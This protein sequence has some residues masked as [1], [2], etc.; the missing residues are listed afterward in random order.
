[1]SGHIG[2]EPEHER[3]LDGL[4]RLELLFLKAEALDLLEVLSGLGGHDVTI[5]AGV[6]ARVAGLLADWATVTLDGSLAV[7]TFFSSSGAIDGAGRFETGSTVRWELSGEVS[8]DIVNRG[9]LTL[10]SYTTLREAVLINHGVITLETSSWQDVLRGE[11]VDDHISRIENGPGGTITTAAGDDGER[12]EVHVPVV[13]DGRITAGH[14]WWSSITNRGQLAVVDDERGSAVVGSLEL[15][16][17]TV[18]GA[19][20]LELSGIVVAAGGGA[21]D[22]RRGVYRVSGE[23]TGV[24]SPSHEERRPSSPMMGT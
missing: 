8:V 16:G 7:S 12:F 3:H 24:P 1:M 6:G 17:G 9:E 15:A 14:S 23:I 19:G 2:L 13:N 11:G 22:A 4:P 5:P 21:L 10:D 20:A 18:S